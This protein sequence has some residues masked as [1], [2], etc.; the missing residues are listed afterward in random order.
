MASL[1]N[2]YRSPMIGAL[3]ELTARE[4]FF[5]NT[6]IYVNE[7]FVCTYV[8]ISHVS[9]VCGGQNGVLDPLELELQ[10][11]W[12]AENQNRFL[13]KSRTVLLITESSLQCGLSILKGNLKPTFLKE[14]FITLQVLLMFVCLYVGIC[15]LVQD[16]QE[17]IRSPKSCSY[18][19]LTRHSA[20]Y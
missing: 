1:K 18:R 19:W 4:Q 2:I 16:V 9:S 7:C 10:M 8:S 15:T 6:F 11:V 12:V 20:E 13:W 14:V 17:T 5:F 3:Q